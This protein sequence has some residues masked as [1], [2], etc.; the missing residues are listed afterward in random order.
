MSDIIISKYIIIKV[1]VSIVA[2]SLRQRREKS[3]MS[4]T[5]RLSSGN[6]FFVV[7]RVLD[8]LGQML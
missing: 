2:V 7:V 8:L 4:S 5:P 3:F 1:F 6:A